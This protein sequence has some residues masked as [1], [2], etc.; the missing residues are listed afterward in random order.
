M[1]ESPT[2][3]DS[4]ANASCQRSDD[5]TARCTT[6]KNI[7]WVCVDLAQAGAKMAVFENRSAADLMSVSTGSA[8]GGR[9]QPGMGQINAYPPVGSIAW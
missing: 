8:E 2:I 6:S 4:L 1:L 7:D 5:L 3:N 9:L